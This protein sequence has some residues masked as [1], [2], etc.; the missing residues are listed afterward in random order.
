MRKFVVF[1]FMMVL[2][3]EAFSQD[4]IMADAIKPSTVGVNLVPGVNVSSM[5]K[6][7]ESTYVV[8]SFCNIIEYSGHT[9]G[10]V[11]NGL[12]A[13]RLSPDGTVVSLKSVAIGYDDSCSVKYAYVDDMGRIYCAVV[14]FPKIKTCFG[15]VNT[16]DKVECLLVRLNSNLEIEWYKR[17]LYG[18]A[19]VGIGKIL[20]HD[21]MIYI[22]GRSGKQQSIPSV[23]PVAKHK[24]PGWISQ[25]KDLWELYNF[26]KNSN[27]NVDT[28]GKYLALYPEDN[29]LKRNYAAAIIRSYYL[30]RDT[31]QKYGKYIYDQQW[32]V[33]QWRDTLDALYSDFELYKN[34]FKDL[35]GTSVTIG[36]KTLSSPIHYL[37]FVAGISAIDGSVVW[38][39]GFSNYIQPSYSADLNKMVWFSPAVPGTST[40]ILRD[41]VYHD[42]SLFVVG[43][44][45]G[46]EIDGKIY[47]GLKLIPSGMNSMQNDLLLMRISAKNGKVEWVQT[48]GG[49]GQDEYM[50]IKVEDD[51]LTVVGRIGEAQK[52]I[53]VGYGLTIDSVVNMRPDTIVSQ[54]KARIQTNRFAKGDDLGTL[55]ARYNTEGRLIN[56]TYIS[57][58]DYTIKNSTDNNKIKMYPLSTDYSDSVF[59][60]VYQISN[61]ND[62]TNSVIVPFNT[63]TVKVAP[64]N[65]AMIAAFYTAKGDLIR[66]I[67]IE[68]SLSVQSTA[69][70]IIEED[71]KFIIAGKSLSQ[72]IKFDID[73]QCKIINNEHYHQNAVVGFIAAGAIRFAPTFTHTKNLRCYESNDGELTVTPFF[74]S[75]TCEYK[76]YKYNQNANDWE[77]LTKNNGTISEPQYDAI[78]DS[79]LFSLSAGR[80]KVV[81]NDVVDG[82]VVATVELER[83]ITQ[84]DK[85]EVVLTPTDV[86]NWCEPNGEMK[87]SVSGGVGQYTYFWSVPTGE[88]GEI[89][90]ENVHLP[91]QSNLSAGRYEITVRDANA[92][93]VTADADVNLNAIPIALIASVNKISNAN[94]DGFIDISWSGGTSTSVE[95]M[96]PNQ[97]LTKITTNPFKLSDL[98]DVGTY[99]ITATDANGCMVDTFVHLTSDAINNVTVVEVG[100]AIFG[101]KDG[102]IMLSS[103]NQAY[104]TMWRRK[105]GDNFVPITRPDCP[106]GRFIVEAGTYEITITF[107]SS[108]S[109]SVSYI[110]HVGVKN[111]LN[112]T[113][114]A[115]PVS[116]YNDNKQNIALVDNG[117]IALQVDGG[118]PPYFFEWLTENGEY[119]GNTQNIS[120]LSAGTYKVKVSDSKGTVQEVSDI[121]VGT[122]DP[123]SIRIA[124][125]KKTDPTCPGKYDGRLEIDYDSISGGNGRYWHIWSN[126]L[127]ANEIHGLGQKRH[128]VTIFDSV[129][130]KYVHSTPIIW[131]RGMQVQVVNIKNPSCAEIADGS[132]QIS[133]DGG[134]PF[135]GNIYQY[136]WIGSVPIAS[137]VNNSLLQNVGVG[138]YLLTVTDQSGCTVEN[139]FTLQPEGASPNISIALNTN[140]I[141]AGEEVEITATGSNGGYNYF[142]DGQSRYGIISDD[143]VPLRVPI[144]DET[145]TYEIYVEGYGDNQ[146]MGRSIKL[147]LTANR[148]PSSKIFNDSSLVWCQGV[149]PVLNLSADTLAGVAGI[150]WTWRRAGQ[151]TD[152]LAK[153]IPVTEPG[154]YALHAKSGKCESKDSVKVEQL[155][156]DNVS[157]DQEGANPWCYGEGNVVTLAAS[158]QNAYSYTWWRNGDTLKLA[159]GRPM[160]GSAIITNIP[161]TY[162]VEAVLGGCVKET[163][164]IEIGH[165]DPI[166]LPAIDTT[167]VAGEPYVIDMGQNNAITQYTWRNITDKQNSYVVQEGGR[168]YEINTY[169]YGDQTLRYEVQVED[170]NGCKALTTAIVRVLKPSAKPTGIGDMELEHLTL[171]PNPTHSGFFVEAPDSDKMLRMYGAGGR[172]VVEHPLNGKTWIS[173]AHLPAGLYIVRTESAGAKVVVE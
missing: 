144:D 55:F 43:S 17:F 31:L 119:K 76:W 83:E 16:S 154:W 56:K 145:K 2:M 93:I 86:T 73:G 112:V 107:G 146:C 122:P 88:N 152:T 160:R 48:G 103:S 38:S 126:T 42:S 53:R 120:G 134:S 92:C 115:N 151:Q 21:N 163:E 133:T 78:T 153:S 142:V 11:G 81:V 128:Y 121:V 35:L 18:D 14:V 25:K 59:A 148:V 118:V 89:R 159:N 110:V 67:S 69:G 22:S 72:K 87:T 131:G 161:G 84:P 149:T 12:Y 155:V 165:R 123:I 39:N 104:E 77:L 52:N 40:T 74:H 99:T 156:V 23:E 19:T 157:L 138:T 15:Y 172:L 9:T 90:P 141:C 173:T 158:V 98:S 124:G 29:L 166:A 41:M 61:L 167:V 65:G 47:H 171:Y 68:D 5:R 94:N 20:V 66:A 30:N 168:S 13:L 58:R 170:N 7:R 79:S 164:V 95:I 63:D 105:E 24:L 101:I 70:I 51:F 137:E 27:Y 116:C 136:E 62:K 60:V 32:L 6:I 85:L 162:R 26:D 169:N 64:Q 36:D 97:T 45:E 46:W 109:G 125:V 75:G 102:W 57:M 34:K 37:H 143:V 8:G 106:S 4:W 117:S 147:P 49:E 114:K 111:N 82:N 54:G 113:W 50:S 130:C 3:L 108:A 132:I 71:R 140:E 100:E 91:N 127:M 135:E 150:E 44:H 10:V 28:I 139:T 129:G 33:T 80:Y 96:S 1:M